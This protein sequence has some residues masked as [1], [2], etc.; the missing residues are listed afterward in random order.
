[1]PSDLPDAQT[2]SARDQILDRPVRAVVITGRSEARAAAAQDAARR[3]AL[4][5]D[6]RLLRVLDVGDH[7]GVAY[8]VTEPVVG[9]DLAQLTAR[10]PLPADQAR[11]VVGE[12]AAALEVARRRGVH[13]LALRPSALRVTS[14]GSVLVTGLA[15]D[16]EL[17]G[18]PSG[19]AKT[20]SRADTVGLV[21]LL[22]LA[23]TGTWPEGAGAPGTGAVAGVLPGQ[24]EDHAEARGDDAHGGAS[25][26]PS[27][28][29]VPVPPSELAPGV[30][31]D[32]DTLCT[33][34]LGPH[35]DGPHSPGELVRELEP[36]VQVD[37][38][39]VFGGIDTAGPADVLPGDLGEDAPARSSRAAAGAAAGPPPTIPPKGPPKVRRQ[40][41]RASAASRPTR[42]G[43]PPSAA[44]VRAPAT[45]PA[46]PRPGPAQP[47]A[48]RPA[49]HPQAVHPGAHPRTPAV[50]APQGRGAPSRDEDFDVLLHQPT[51]PVRRQVNAT[52]IVLGIVA[53]LL[54]VGA[55]W[56]FRSL[57]A[58]APP[59]GGEAGLGLTEPQ[60]GDAEPAGEDEESPDAEAPA[61][62]GEGDA[63][64]PAASGPPVIAGAQMVDPPP[65]GDNNEHPE[66]VDRAIDGD[67]TT[68]W[69]TRTYASPTFGMK[70]GVGY[71]V[72]LAQPATVTSVRL[73]V[74][75]LGGMVEIRATD[76]ATPTE[77]PVLATGSLQP[78][79]V[80][81]L[82][83]PT[84]TQHIV[85]WF[86]V[87][88]QTP[89]GKNRV[90][91]LEVSVS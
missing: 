46:T 38:K 44:P 17:F 3:A 12:A 55:V 20:T 91:L 4:V 85:L 48:A 43:T 49:A 78:D 74:N 89:D 15:M 67:P 64:A 72:T 13:H 87:L 7:E 65:G 42:P 60:P 70:P 79:T 26:A 6:P 31:G 83:E 62:E 24:G 80:F 36:W 59:I 53:L 71:A 5:S 8:V 84:T 76:P 82:S 66:L 40:S 2:W 63:G 75:G 52:P 32:L 69:I 86:T 9:K 56:A 22:Y 14:D 23:L 37:A 35:D 68:S 77:G 41:A 29:G 50:L 10:G 81:T 34:T 33:V 27:V 11:A 61:A 16:G 39:V 1:V 47:Q 58:P 28:G 25:I 57:T 54:V 45:A 21:A 30:P 18:H 73:Q 90:E 51:S 88:P 19:D